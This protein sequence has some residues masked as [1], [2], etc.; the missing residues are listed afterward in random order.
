MQAFRGPNDFFFKF[1]DSDIQLGQRN[2][3]PM[4]AHLL[5]WPSRIPDW[6]RNGNYTK[7]QIMDIMR[8]WITTTMQRY[9][10]IKTW[11]V[12]NEAYN[13]DFFQTRLGDDY[14]IEFYKIA[15]EAR[16][17]AILIYNDYSNHSL[18][19]QSFYN[20]QRTNLTR[21]I[22]E[23]LR[24]SNLI[25]GVGVQMIIYADHPPDYQDLTET[26]R[27][28]GLPIYV[29]EFQ[30]IMS[31]ISGSPEKRARKQA[32]IYYNIVKSIRNSNSVNTIIFFNQSDKV[33]PWEND[34]NLPQYSKLADPTLFD[35][36]YN[37]KPSYYSVLSAFFK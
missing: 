17:D 15:R 1:I 11:E 18:R 21:N 24:A 7:D 12:V 13:N 16:P 27:S 26:L 34:P 35:D 8:N 5:I 4:M 9:P 20:G 30:V 33:S 28:Y 14:I 6:L 10:Q 2:N 22:V 32:E 37:P 31:N 23:R 25:D 19:D 36:N 3:M 29:T